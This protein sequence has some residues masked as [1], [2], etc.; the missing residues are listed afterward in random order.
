[1]GMFTSS[2]TRSNTWVFGVRSAG[3]LFLLAAATVRADSRA[4]LS[5]SD[6]PDASAQP[7]DSQSSSPRPQLPDYIASVDLTATVMLPAGLDNS[8]AEYSASKAGFGFD[9]IKPFADGSAFGVG[10]SSAA[11]FYSFSD[12][13]TLL[14]GNEPWGT[15]ATHGI[16]AFYS[17]PR[18]HGFS[19]L[20]G[21]Q[22]ES[23]GELGA[24][25]GDTLTFGGLAGFRYHV[26]EGLFLG[27]GVAVATR[28]EDS[29]LVIPLPVVEWTI[30]DQWSL[31]TGGGGAGGG[32]V[33]LEYAPS[34]QWN[35]ALSA[36]FDS[37]RF[38]LDDE[39]PNPGGIGEDSS[40]PI[41]LGATWNFDQQGSAF[42]RVIV[43]VWRQ[44]RADDPDGNTIFEHDADITPSFQFGIEGRF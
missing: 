19:Y 3:V 32:G 16:Q 27:L 40:V 26:G 30:D 44:L 10:L 4:V 2:G 14:G 41:S 18:S 36:G 42:V 37:V 22:V 28:L 13:Q 43:P 6:E 17:T 7:A 35:F 9:V 34:E 33:T 39:G 12:A 8:P 11:T 5:L 25:L 31:K 29:T 20:F 24:D 23:S 38:R 15:V 21:V 1:M